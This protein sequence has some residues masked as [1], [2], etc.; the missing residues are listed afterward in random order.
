M[1]VVID[2]FGTAYSSLSDLGHFPMDFLN[3]DRSL[4]LKLGVDPKD[5][6]VVSAMINLAHALGWEV[7][8]EGVETADQLARLREL[9][10][11]MAQGNY[12]WEPSSIEE[13]SAFLRS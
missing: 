6:A 7:T 1:R 11:D 4:T 10:C 12:L 13:V 9:G 8:A 3:I 5:T 2:D